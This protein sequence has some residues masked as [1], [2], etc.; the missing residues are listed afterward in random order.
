MQVASA[1]RLSLGQR[2]RAHRI[3]TSSAVRWPVYQ[4][5]PRRSSMASRSALYLAR[6]GRRRAL[7][8]LRSCRVR[9]AAT[10]SLSGPS[11]GAN[12]ASNSAISASIQGEGS[13]IR[14]TTAS[15]TID[16]FRRTGT[17]SR[18]VD[19]GATYAPSMVGERQIVDGKALDRLLVERA[20]PLVDRIRALLPD[21]RL[22]GSGLVPE[23]AESWTEEDSLADAL[24]FLCERFLDDLQDDIMF[25]TTEIWPTTSSGEIPS[26][27]VEVDTLD[28]V[29]RLGYIAGEERFDLEPIRFDEIR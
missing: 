8:S 28:Q 23:L 7:A 9:E 1:P 25:E 27:Y 6:T 11:S 26:C 21:D 19:N 18:V 17:A 22:D 4:G 2:D 15:L 12:R 3:G 10:A 20:R 16:G 13:T 14:V 24:G 29:V 5:K